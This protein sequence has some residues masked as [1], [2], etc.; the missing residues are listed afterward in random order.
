M[1]NPQK[2]SNTMILQFTYKEI[3]S[4]IEKEFKLRPKFTSSNE[5]SVTLSYRPAPLMP[6]IEVKFDIEAM[7]KDI[8]CLSYDCNTAASLIITGVVAYLDEKIPSGIEISTGDKR[9]NIFPYRFK[10]LE[11]VLER[12]ELSN[13]Y[14]TADS[15][16]LELKMVE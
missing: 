7:R 10:E 3:A 11:S 13:I 2:N 4:Y 14:F 1:F 15:I 6:P 12:V 16:N 8:V 9:L 5:K